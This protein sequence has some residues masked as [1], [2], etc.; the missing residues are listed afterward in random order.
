MHKG[1]SSHKHDHGAD[2]YVRFISSSS[3]PK[4][5]TRHQIEEA[6]ES[7]VELRSVRITIETGQFEECKMLHMLQVSCAQLGC[8]S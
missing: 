3:T 7:D 6:S 8:W 5:L 1:L 2:E 4:A